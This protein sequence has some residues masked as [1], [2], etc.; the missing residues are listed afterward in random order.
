MLELSINL[1][2]R[3]CKDNNVNIQIFTEPYFMER[4]ELFGYKK[5]YENFCNFIETN[6]NG[7]EEKYLA[8]YNEIKDEI[9]NYIKNS[10]AYKHLNFIADMNTFKVDKFPNVSMNGD[11]YKIPNIGREFVSVD[12]SKANFSALVHYGKATNTNFFT[13]YDFDKFMEL[14]TDISHI[15]KSKYIRQVVFGNC[16]PKR[17]VTYE[18]YLICKFLEHMLN[19]L[20][21]DN[22]CIKVICSDEVVLDVTNLDSRKIKEMEN[23]VKIHNEFEDNVPLHFEYFKLGKFT[24]TNAF[25]KKIYKS[26]DNKEE[27]TLKEKCASPLEAPFIKRLLKGEDSEDVDCLFVYENKVARLLKPLKIEIGFE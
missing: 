22:S 20:G 24:N 13:S 27:F 17:Q 19:S 3:F 21:L 4:I 9:I 7:E 1:K 26:V 18:K 11:V 2:K 25:V 16:N 10:S 8:K 6:F 12:M 23:Y 14:F 15:K 5:E